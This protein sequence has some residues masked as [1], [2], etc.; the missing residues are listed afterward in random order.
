MLRQNARAASMEIRAGQ[1]AVESSILRPF[2]G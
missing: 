1:R 2:S